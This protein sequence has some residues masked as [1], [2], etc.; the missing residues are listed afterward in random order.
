MVNLSIDPGMT[1]TGICVWQDGKFVTT[2]TVYGPRKTTK[3]KR[4]NPV[5]RSDTQRIVTLFD[6]VSTIFADLA[7]IQA[8]AVE[9]FENFDRFRANDMRMC[10]AA[11][12]VIILAL[13]NHTV[14]I[15]ELSK[16]KRPK[17]EADLIAKKY[18][19]SLAPAQEHE[20]DALHIGYLAGFAKEV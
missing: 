13:S 1:A 5:T 7:P 11:R 20:R 12:A 18:G 4:G 15:H 10:A 17:S 2:L 14:H 6:K 8:A 19:V 16:K 9:S 3:T